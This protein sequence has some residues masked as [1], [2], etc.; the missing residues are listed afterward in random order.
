MLNREWNK[1]KS[2]L[3]IRADRNKEEVGYGTIK[4]VYV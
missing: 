3:C 4:E 1:G 2:I